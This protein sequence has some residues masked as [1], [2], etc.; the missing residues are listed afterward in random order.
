[1]LFIFMYYKHNQTFNANTPSPPPPQNK[2]HM[3]H[4]I[5]KAAPHKPISQKA[6]WAG[7]GRVGTSGFM[8]GGGRGKTRKE[9]DIRI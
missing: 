2:F 5:S 4:T 1:M 9:R 8:E 6:L 3:Q 7:Q